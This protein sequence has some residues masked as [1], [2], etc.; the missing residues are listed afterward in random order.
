[1][2]VFLHAASLLAVDF[3]P[4]D[5]DP[6]VGEI[7]ADRLANPRRAL[8]NFGFDPLDRSLEHPQRLAQRPLLAADGFDMGLERPQVG[9]RREHR[10]G[11]S[12]RGR[13]ADHDRHQAQQDRQEQHC[14]DQFKD[15]H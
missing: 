11:G 14:K 10:I 15:A 5:D 8:Q 4:F 13:P 6:G 9:E 1:M 12:I 3:Q 7:L 2:H